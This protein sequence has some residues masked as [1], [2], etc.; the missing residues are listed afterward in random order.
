ME[1]YAE[2]LKDKR[3]VSDSDVRTII[4]S[5]QRP[6]DVDEK[7][8]NDVLLNM[9]KNRNSEITVVEDN[10]LIRNA[11]QTREN[12]EKE[13][14][15]RQ[16]VKLTIEQKRARFYPSVYEDAIPKFYTNDEL[17]FHLDNI[18]RLLQKDMDDVFRL[19]DVDV[20]SPQI[21]DSN[22]D[23]E[24][25][26]A[27]AEEEKKLT[28]NDIEV[29]L[30]TMDYS[31]FYVGDRPNV[32]IDKNVAAAAE[33]D[34]RREMENQLRRITIKPRRVA[35]YTELY[36]QRFYRSLAVP[37]KYVG[38]IMASSYGE[39]ATQQTLN[40]F[41]FA[42]D[43]N[44]RKQLNGLPKFEAI[45]DVNEKPRNPGITIFTKDSYNDEQLRMKIPMFQMTTMGQII[46]SYRILGNDAG[47]PPAPRWEQVSDIIRGVPVEYGGTVGIRTM[48]YVTAPN[49]EPARLNVHRGHPAFTTDPL[50]LKNK[51][52]ILE[53]KF[54]IKELYF[55]KITLGQI[56]DAIEEENSKVRVVTS[57]MDIGLIYIY[58]PFKGL[59]QESLIGGGEIPAF[60]EA[61][62]FTVFLKQAYFPKIRELQIGGIYG[63]D[64][65]SI[66]SYSI[67]KAIDKQNSTI[68]TRAPVSQTDGGAA[69]NPNRRLSLYF[70]QEECDRWALDE[71]TL[72]YF[73]VMKLGR[74]VTPGY[75]FDLK[76]DEDDGIRIEFNTIGLMKNDDL[77]GG[78]TQLGKDDIIS[79]LEGTTKIPIYDLL[80]EGTIL[81]AAGNLNAIFDTDPITINNGILTIDF[82]GAKLRSFGFDLLQL[83]STITSII[84][85]DINSDQQSD[86]GKT[87]K[88]ASNIINVKLDLTLDEKLSLLIIKGIPGTFS[89][90]PQELVNYVEEKLKETM[91]ISE[92]IQNSSLKWFYEADG[93]NL[94]EILAHPA[95]NARYSR[96]DNG[97]EIFRTLGAESYRAIIL[98]EIAANVKEGINPAHIELLADALSSKT[99]GDKPLAQNRNGLA[100]RGA[101]FIARGFETTTDSFM[102]AGLGQVDNLSSFPAQIMIGT[103]AKNGGLPETDRRRILREDVFQYDFPRKQRQKRE[104]EKRED[105]KRIDE[106]EADVGERKERSQEG[107][108]F[109]I[110]DRQTVDT[111]L[112]VP[113][114]SAA[115]VREERITPS[116]TTRQT[117][118]STASKSRKP[119]TVKEKMAQMARKGLLKQKP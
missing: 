103:L 95:V 104:N 8:F 41:H 37:G 102:K 32:V 55:R 88:A 22:P 89:P 82:D 94:I 23:L 97:V 19:P 29:I 98:H 100:K 92:A 13:M 110:T 113:V 66:Q 108:T 7:L 91:A 2:V 81:P 35:K 46:E 15:A 34:R 4:E 40:T 56:S 60:A 83:G 111:N 30:N 75:I 101:E 79:E 87:R 76:Y 74:F 1:E 49:I 68:P 72:S 44:A 57:S 73:V 28:D 14:N 93:N 115:V 96:S 80:R 78:K 99:P 42:G 53:I 86:L 85:S 112:P 109:N 106:R 65:V 54:D 107:S 48:R 58:Y 39:A 31:K 67:P 9:V 71:F 64:Y 118:G 3:P 18:T 90:G 6:N 117:P 43:R 62:P 70:K 16:D 24:I 45:V 50:T 105:E 59:T 20:N 33:R 114:V 38:N 47:L 36:Q 25:I 61:D 27:A 10:P 77:Y 84:E 116:A 119:L 17:Q 63:I 26:A 52:R 5:I 69:F 51:G 12:E 21:E 11:L